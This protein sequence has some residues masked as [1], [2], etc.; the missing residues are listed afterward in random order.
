[1]TFARRDAQIYTELEPI[2]RDDPAS[3]STAIEYGLPTGF[4]G[5]AHACWQYFSG[6]AYLFEYKGR[7]VMTDESLELTEY[8]D[9]SHEAPLG[10]P[11][12]AFDSWDEVETWLEAVYDDLLADDLL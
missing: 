12:G 6:A 3:A 5:K 2:D 8:G 11:R 1:M 7:L 9:G 10:A 4:S